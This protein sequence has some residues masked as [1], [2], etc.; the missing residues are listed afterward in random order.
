MKSLQQ[1]IQD[2]RAERDRY[3][4]SSLLHSLIS[5]R[6]ATYE[7]TLAMLQQKRLA[8]RWYPSFSY[9]V[10]GKVYQPPP[11]AKDRIQELEATVDRARGEW[12]QAVAGASRSGGLI[13]AFA[14]MTAETQG[15][16]VAQ[17]EYQLAAYRYGFPPFAAVTPPPSRGENTTANPVGSTA[18]AAPVE[19]DAMRQALEVRLITK[20]Y[21][22]KDIHASRF[23]DYV[24]FRLEYTNRS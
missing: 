23:S 3:G 9:T 4:A 17:L 13:G 16:K 7:Q 1:Q 18:S 24:S 14:T 6:L 8:I 12:K 5:L 19:N 15:L 11:D 20:R 10:D 22:P 2:T 21:I